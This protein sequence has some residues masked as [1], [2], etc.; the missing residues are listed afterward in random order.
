MLTE[1][2]MKEVRRLQVRTRRRVEGLFSGEYHSAFKGR[3]I[4]F[5]EVREYEPGD[6]VRSIDWNVTARTGRTFVK[7]FVEERELQVVLAVDLSRSG[8]FTSGGGGAPEGAS[9]K[10]KSRVAVEVAAVVAMSASMNNDRVG[11]LIFTDSVELFVPPRKGRLHVLRVLRELLNF[12]PAGRGTDVAGA[13]DHMGRV[14]TKR[15]IVFVVSDFVSPEYE[16]SLRAMSQRH[17]VIGVAVHDPRERDLPP[18][19]LVQVADAETGRTGLIDA[20]SR[21]VREAY[22]RAFE[23][24]RSERQRTLRRARADQIEIWTDRPFV[25][26][27]VKYFKLRESR[28]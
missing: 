23:R 1:D 6:D 12:E 14:L 8:A 26:E 16:R 20:S 25:P 19:G 10:L 2:L 4:E 9:A 18:V 22:A 15:S 7:R 3:G 5:A 24:A 17:E 21:V 27:L 13:L 11:L 28:R